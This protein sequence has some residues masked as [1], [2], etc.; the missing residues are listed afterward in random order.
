MSTK[1]SDPERLRLTEDLRGERP[2]KLWGPYLSERQ[3]GTV[4][5]DYSAGGTAW[6]YFPH[7]HAR[8][9]AYR[10]GEDGIAGFS[11]D[12][13]QLCLALAL[14][15]GQDPILKERLFG[16]N[17]SEGNH[18]ED[19]KELYYYLDATPTH[20]YMKYLYKYPQR[21][22][23]YDHLVSE[24]AHRGQHQ[25]E[26]ELLDTGV[27]DDDRYFDVFVEYAKA[28]P[29]DILMRITVH[30]RG[31]DAAT[32]DLLPQLWFRNIWSWDHEPARPQIGLEDG[33]LVARHARLGAYHLHTDGE[34]TL[35]FTEN[36]TN[37]RRLFG[38]EDA[39]GPFKD[40]FH[41]HLVEGQADALAQGPA[42]TKVAM[43]ERREIATGG[44]TQMRLRLIKDGEGGSFTDFDAV[45]AQR[46]A[47]AD[48]FYAV[49]QAKLADADARNVQRQAWA[50]M[51]WSKQFFDYD[52]SRWLDGDPNQPPPP[53]ERL[54]GR[55]ADWRHLSNYDVISMPDK[56]EYPWYAAWD[57]AFHCIP[58]AQIDAEFAKQ[59]LIQLCRVWYMHPNGQ[60]P[61]YE[62]AFGDVNPP[63][64]AWAA[65]RVFQIDRQQRGGKGDLAF[66]ERI[67]HKLLLNFTWWVNRKDAQDRHVFQGGFLGLDN[68]GVFDRSKPLPTGGHIN[69]SDGTGWMAMYCLNL[70]RIALELGQH[71]HV[72]ED[73]AG[74]FFEHFL[75]IAQAM[76]NMAGQGIG[77]WDEDD[78]FFYDELYLPD[79]EILPLKVRS[80]VGLI[81]L[82]AVETIDPGTLDQMPQFR[83]RLD[84]F[85]NYRPELCGL[86]SRWREP[87]LGG[88]RLLSLLRGYRMKSLLKRMLDETE[89]LS[90]YG[91]RAL[92]KA[93]EHDPY[94]FESQGHRLTVGYEPAESQ[95]GMFGGNSNW[96]GPIWFPV[97]YLLIEAL[98]RFHHYYGDALTVE[99]PTGSGNLMTLEQV[100]NELSRRLG[101]IFLRDE[102]GRRAAFGDHPKLQNDTHFRDYPMFYEYFHGD[103][104]C[105]V[106]ASHQTGW[107]GLVAKLLQPRV[108]EQDPSRRR[109]S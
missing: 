5:E 102:Q 90:D 37:T 91:I 101:R 3:W 64:H 85:L 84:W 44:S 15:N 87:G 24:N 32:I 67:L 95:S 65:W 40:A 25:P 71:N 60:M 94:V 50:G 88:R 79:G 51:I 31:P 11:D 63:V 7:D 29:D 27:F 45:F 83:D 107:T 97:N 41:A 43:H 47:E 70:M 36:D 62:W 59:Q 76:T 103:T 69:Q 2:W 17:N 21:A 100:A 106:G 109:K 77:M 73:I 93:H 13:Q 98:Q 72:Y 39:S 23:P 22:Y 89:F 52:V 49:L 4:R 75:Y 42:G 16:L 78:A 74:K 86:V 28:S 81:P 104:A 80:M 92:S 10:W 38:V 82:F 99:C 57:L 6:D 20:S 1:K 8:S 48:G 58:L 55:N 18:G 68:I 54:S 33:T 14:W 30:N 34:P 66:L 35:L 105:G 53:H 61:A 9:R 12:R 26:F 108:P 96:R 46:Q 19:V 56:W